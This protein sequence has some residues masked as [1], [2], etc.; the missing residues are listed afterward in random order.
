MAQEKRTF[1]WKLTPREMRMLLYLLVLLGFA[2]WKFVPRPWHPSL[3]LETPCHIIYST[4][5]REQ[6]EATA[7]A[8]ELLYGAYSNRFGHFAGFQHE[9]PRLKVKLFKDREEFRRINP[10]LGWGE[11]YYREPYCR[12]Y[13]SSSEINPYHWMLHEAVHQLN[14][15]VAHLKLAKWLDEG[16]A[17]YFSTSRFVSNELAVGRVDLNTYPVWWIDDIATSPDLAE[18][19][20]AIAAGNGDAALYDKYVAHLA[21][22]KTPQEYNAYLQSL[23]MFPDKELARRTFDIILGPEVK[24]QNVFSLYSLMVNY[25]VQPTAWELFKQN[26]PRLEKKV[27]IETA[28]S[29]AQ[30]SSVFCD[31]NLRDDSQRFFAEKNLPG[32]KRILQ[33]AREQVNSCIQV[34]ELQ[35][36]NLSNYLQQ[37]QQRSGE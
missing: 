26:F 27:G 5:T 8:L 9:H 19:A 2:A 6:T 17:E 24:G 3:T 30:M 22:A 37:H 29:F 28:S 32:T 31:P 13:F 12:A 15:E 11:A 23:G 4:A 7:H 10:G 1:G 20:L 34:R 36:K 18:K 35:Q 21:T 14:H 25:E 33:N 16:L